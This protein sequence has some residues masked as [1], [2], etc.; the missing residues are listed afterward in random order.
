MTAKQAKTKADAKIF[1]ILGKFV[2]PLAKVESPYFCWVPKSPLNVEIEVRFN[3]LSI[4][5]EASCSY[6]MEIPPLEV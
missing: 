2:T 6:A 4:K 5:L 1:T 3:D